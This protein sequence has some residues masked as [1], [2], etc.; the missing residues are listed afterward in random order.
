M[1]SLPTTDAWADSAIAAGGGSRWSY[2]TLYWPTAMW[3][4]VSGTVDPTGF[5]V[6]PAIGGLHNAYAASG[7]AASMS[8]PTGQDLGRHSHAYTFR[9]DQRADTICRGEFTFVHAGGAQDF[10]K[11]NYF[12]GLGAR[13]QGAAGTDFNAQGRY[14]EALRAPSGYWFM[15]LNRWNGGGGFAITRFAILKVTGPGS[16]GGISTIEQLA[17]TT[18]SVNGQEIITGNTPFELRF[19]C[20]TSGGVVELRGYFLDPTTGEETQVLSYDDG[21]GAFTS[22]GHPAF[23]VTSEL[24]DTSGQSD[25]KFVGGISMFEVQDDGGTPVLRDEFERVQVGQMDSYGPDKHARTGN[26]VSGAFTGDQAGK[27]ISGEVPDF[28]DRLIRHSSTA[29]LESDD[30]PIGG[31]H[32]ATDPPSNPWKQSAAADFEFGV[33]SS[34]NRIFGVC[35]RMALGDNAHW[36]NVAGTITEKTG[37]VVA[38]TLSGGVWAMRLYAHGQS[39]WAVIAHRTMNASGDAVTLT[40]STTFT[41]RLDVENRDGQSPADGN[42]HLSPTID[43]EKFTGW[44]VIDG[45]TEE[46]DG[47]IT[48]ARTDRVLAGP[49]IGFFS[50]GDGSEDLFCHEWDR[51]VVTFDL[52]ERE[53]R[54]QSLGWEKDGISGTLTTPHAW[55][56]RTRHMSYAEAI[57]Y[58]SGHVH[59]HATA[60]SQRRVWRIKN[61]A[62]KASEVSGL[63]AFFDARDG[64]D[65]PFNWTTPEGEAVVVRYGDDTLKI[66]KVTLDVYQFEVELYECLGPDVRLSFA[67]FQSSGVAASGGGL[68][69]VDTPSGDRKHPVFFFHDTA[70]TFSFRFGLAEAAPAGGVWVSYDLEGDA[71]EGTHFTIPDGPFLIPAGDT[72]LDVTVTVLNTGKYHPERLLKIKLAATSY[73]TRD[74]YDVELWA[75]IVSTTAAPE[76]VFDSAAQNKARGATASIGVSKMS[77]ANDTEENVSVYLELDPSSTAVEG[78][79]FDYQH[80]LGPNGFYRMNPTQVAATPKIDIRNNATPGRT[81]VLNLWHEASDQSE[82]NLHTKSEDYRYE[83]VFAPKL[84]PGE[85]TDNSPGPG[86]VIPPV[87]YD[88]FEDGTLVTPHGDPVWVFR[89]REDARGTGYHRKSFESQVYCAGPHDL[90]GGGMIGM[91]LYTRFSMYVRKP[92]NFVLPR[93]CRLSLRDRGFKLAP[94]QATGG[95]QKNVGVT[96]D[97]QSSNSGAISFDGGSWDV[98]ETSSNWPSSGEYGIAQESHRMPD[99][100]LITLLRLW[101]IYH[102]NDAARL[103][104]A[105]VRLWY[106]MFTANGVSS[107][108]DNTGKGIGYFWPHVEVS[109]SALSGAPPRYPSRDGFFWTP[110][111][112]A[113]CPV[114]GVRQH[115]VTIT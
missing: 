5:N 29:K 112:A 57:R 13:I 46:S 20:I 39:S 41:M 48:D 111:G 11:A 86:N 43:S 102:E 63:E 66:Q 40:V 88:V 106:P 97:T 92:T 114:G 115:T 35:V 85:P 69:I 74:E 113:T 3:N 73:G 17:A 27:S 25:H 70:G 61:D 96:F 14:L 79:D 76:I 108:G 22:Q 99:G 89:Q 81:V 94:P 58:E 31:F 100:T 78:T 1:Q 55:P 52:D 30:T 21:S 10:Y 51:P 110:K 37:Y 87:P 47:T 8:L 26:S 93:L 83:D 80:V 2:P 12:A 24:D 72:Y 15:L 75:Y 68:G 23:V 16:A 65:E 71:V 19:S 60:T 82:M 101:I 67:D 62:A 107:F 90:E 109:A 104:N 34:T 53:Q 95:G 18:Y 64:V 91:P 38:L 28:K 6:A 84:Y 45:V 56:V 59:T 98:L 54:S 105:M 50:K 42:V 33:G 4:D 44:T 9:N 36:E 103:G 7:V 49:A 32:L 77:G